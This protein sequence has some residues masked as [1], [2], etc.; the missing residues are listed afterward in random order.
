M[1]LRSKTWTSQVN[2]IWFDYFFV[3]ITRHIKWNREGQSYYVGQKPENNLYMGG[4]VGK[5]DNKNKTV[6][7]QLG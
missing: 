6:G 2:F 5:T 4:K 3:S 1:G 7:W